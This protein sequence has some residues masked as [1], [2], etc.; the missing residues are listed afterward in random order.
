MIEHMKHHSNAG[1]STLD[2]LLKYDK[3]INE[4]I[5]VVNVMQVDIVSLRKKNMTPTQKKKLEKIE[6]LKKQLK[7]LEMEL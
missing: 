6:A 3:K 4:L 2:A 7:Q 5:R 1:D